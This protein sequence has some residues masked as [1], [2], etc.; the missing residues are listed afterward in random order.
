MNL[1]PADLSV[2]HSCPKMTEANSEMIILKYDSIFC[3][4]SFLPLSSSNFCTSALEQIPLC[5][6]QFSVRHTFF[7]IAVHVS[8]QEIAATCS[9]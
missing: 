8:Q 5:L 6:Q 3:D 4:S 7:L 2:L 1:D 9:L